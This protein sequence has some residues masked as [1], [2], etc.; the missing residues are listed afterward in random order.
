[1]L[2][3]IVRGQGQWKISVKA[4]QQLPQILRSAADVVVRIVRIPHV[5]AY[6]CLRHQLHEAD[7]AGA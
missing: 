4:V 5:E 3:G 1:V 6:C 7:R 2:S